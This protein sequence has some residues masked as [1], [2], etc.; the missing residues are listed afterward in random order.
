MNWQPLF[1]RRN[2]QAGTDS[3]FEGMFEKALR[4][5]QTSLPEKLRIPHAWLACSPLS[6][7]G[8]C[9]SQSAAGGV[10]AF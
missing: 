5:Q 3:A 10:G 4:Q 6:T 7:T 1:P 2:P 9:R 8:H